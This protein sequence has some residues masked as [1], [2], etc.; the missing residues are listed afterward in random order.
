MDRR[1]APDEVPGA[2]DTPADRMW[3]RKRPA[4]CQ[5]LEAARARIRELEEELERLERAEG[6][7]SASAI[8]E[9]AEEVSLE[10]LFP[11]Q[12]LQR[13]QDAFSNAT[14]VASIITHPDG[15]PI[16]K[17]SNFCRL[18]EGV[19]RKTG[20]G[21]ANCMHSDAVIGRPN[22][23]GPIMQP[24]L[25]GGLWDGGASITVGDRHLANWLIG[26]VRNDRQDEEA[27]LAYAREIGA[28]E[29]DFLAALREVP[30]MSTEQFSRTCDALFLFAN[31]MSRLAYHDMQQARWLQS[32][33]ETERA[34]R[35]SEQR[36]RALVENAN[37]AVVVIQDGVF[38]F[39]NAK[40]TTLTG[41]ERETLE[42]MAFTDVVHPDDRP[43]LMDTH[44]RRLAG[45]SLPDMYRFRAMHASGE[46]RWAQVSAVVI[47]WNDRPA[48]LAFLTDV[49]ELTAAQRAIEQGERHLREVVENMPVM[50]DAFDDRGNIIVWNREC[51][52]VTGYSAEEVVNNPHALEM[53]YPDEIYRA[54]MLDQ[55][56]KM[57][58]GFRSREWDL[59]CKDGTQRTIAWS[60]IS[61]SVQIP[62]WTSWAVGVDV[63]EQRSAEEALRESEATLRSIVRSAPAGIVILRD[64]RVVWCNERA[65][66]LVGRTR[67]EVIG[68]DTRMLY[69]DGGEYARVGRELY[70]LSGERD[71]GSVRARLVHGNGREVDVLLNSARLDPKDPAAG[72]T[73]TMLDVTDYHRAQEDYRNLFEKM[74]DGF[75]VHEIICDDTGKPVDYKFLAVNPAF[76]RMTGLKAGNVVGRTVREVIP[77]VEDFWIDVYGRVTLTGEAVQF[78]QHAAGLG[79]YFNVSAYRPAP[80]RF[81]CI[82]VD[83]TARKR[84]EAERNR[85]ASAIDQAAEAVLVIGRDGT[86]QYTNASF[87]RNVGQTRQRLL[88]QSIDALAVDTHGDSFLAAIRSTMGSGML[89]QGRLRRQGADGQE[90]IAEVTISPVRDETGAITDYAAVERDVTHEAELE[91]RLRQ[92]QKMEAIGTLAGGI[93]HDF[94]NILSAILGYTELAMS[95]VPEGDRVRTMLE[96]VRKAGGRATDLVGQILTFSRQTE[97]EM[98]P[99]RVQPV[100]KEALKLLRASL[101]ATINMN[102][103]V[104]ESCGPILADSTQIHQVVM[105]LCT[106]AYQAM[107]HEGGTLTVVLDEVASGLSVDGEL[108]AGPHVR[109]LV[110]DTGHG[111]DEQTISRIFEPY[112]TTK[113][114]GTGTGL[115]LA[116]VHGIVRG[117]GGAIRVS[118]LPGEGSTFEVYFPV[119]N[120][121]DVGGEE[122]GTDA[123]PTGT[124]TVLL[125][126]DEVAIGEMWR[127]GLEQLGYRPEKCSDA[128]AALELFL[129]DPG[130]FDII[131]TDHAMPGMTG[132][133]LCRKVRAVSRSVPIVLCTGFT[134]PTT[135]AQVSAAGANALLPKPASALNVARTIRRLLDEQTE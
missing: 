8:V 43:M 65:L 62:G 79:S 36:Y 39:L 88:G 54:I 15:R 73:V 105:N 82:F 125:V 56:T 131:V 30:V 13:M 6:R 123:L 124:E 53:L 18:C 119:C 23:D 35:E 80:G 1:D 69:S 32:H 48:I 67:A 24:C 106:N 2:G 46:L 120:L 89:W 126:D 111:M 68:N 64:R 17:P 110:A 12:E 44:V 129:H 5:T 33:V 134:E 121:A 75:A 41:Y 115:G 55:W 77:D 27:M 60:N 87:E 47:Q 116:T 58:D 19:I 100:L 20:K 21:L 71:T 84:V 38:R 114:P 42:G 85:L 102:Q 57:G 133:E 112:F 14:G 118:S 25:S 108:G 117:H 3:L 93:A 72:V 81:A 107:Q 70:G 51:E 59:T 135:E 52:R 113:E 16:T 4:P 26:Q 103:D 37:E 66:E 92:A 29:E 97:Q 74:L 7:V 76:E 63:T 83:V 45:E 96:Q 122:H 9:H 11:V 50:L 90:Y 104:R 101:P 61:D 91:S 94:N 99:V 10:D 130:R 98:R 128:G 132:L 49:T 127:Y 95:T 28:D 22:A 78:E 34:L 31:Q 40:T 109:L 86:V